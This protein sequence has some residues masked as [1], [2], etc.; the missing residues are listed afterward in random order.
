MKLIQKV[1]EKQ[2]AIQWM[3]KAAEVAEKSLCLRSRCGT[4]IVKDDAV[5][6]KGYNAPPLDDQKYRVC[7]NEYQLPQKFKY[8]R[9]CCVHAE[10]RAIMDA[11]KEHQSTLEGADLYFIRI[12]EHGSRE[13]AGEPY[14]TVCS[15]MAL[16]VGISHFVLWHE[17]GIC[18][19]ETDEYNRLSYAYTASNDSPVRW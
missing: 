18:A 1:Q 6:G 19:Y 12:D 3:E 15:R 4:V 10:Q 2:V 9:T 17:K 11:L 8:D 7:L 5:I 14:C 13:K 16:D